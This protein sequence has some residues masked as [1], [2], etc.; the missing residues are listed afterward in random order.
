MRAWAIVV[1]GLGG[2]GV[3]ASGCTNKELEQK[4]AASEARAAASEA[5]VA[6]CS[7]TASA[8]A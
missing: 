2:I 6:A 8:R 7:A 1:V 3:G 5:Q 4:L